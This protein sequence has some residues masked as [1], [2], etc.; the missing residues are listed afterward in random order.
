MGRWAVERL[1]AVKGFRGHNR[2]L[3]RTAQLAIAFSAHAKTREG[4]NRR[5]VIFESGSRRFDHHGPH[6]ALGDRT[7]AEYLRA[8]RVEDPASPMKETRAPDGKALTEQLLSRRRAAVDHQ[9]RSLT[10]GRFVRR[11]V[12]AAVRHLFGCARTLH[13]A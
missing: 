8:L 1:D 3:A 10:I 11:E 4:E 12:K 6:Q 9:N 13:R 5:R 2:I 7:P